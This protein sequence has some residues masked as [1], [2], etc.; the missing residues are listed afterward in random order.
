MN[1]FRFSLRGETLEARATGTLWWPAAGM[2]CVSDLHLG[3]CER[4]ARRRG[5]LL[6]PYADADTLDRL[7]A[8]IAALDPACVLTLGD[9]FDDTLAGRALA[10]ETR[11]RLLALGAQRRWIWVEGNHDPGAL[12]LPGAWVSAH[13]LGP[14]VFRHIAQSAD[15]EISGHFHPKARVPLGQATVS[16]ACF[17][18]DSGRVVMPAFGTYT[19]G[20]CATDPALQDLMEPRAL[21]V[22]TGLR[23]VALPMPRPAAARRQDA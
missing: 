1:H 9:S 14:L 13:R 22:L 18:I 6:P 19:G 23:A 7:A 5:G 21:A 15:G 8:E 20:L 16:R 17:L 10:P 12:D 11:A 2:L 4:T 3:R